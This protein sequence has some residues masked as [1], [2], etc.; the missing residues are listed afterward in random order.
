M[1]VTQPLRAGDLKY[2]HAGSFLGHTPKG[3]DYWAAYRLD[4]KGSFQWTYRAKKHIYLWGFGLI[5]ATFYLCA[6]TQEDID[7]AA[8]GKSKDRSFMFR[9]PQNDARALMPQKVVEQ[10]IL[11]VTEMVWGILVVMAVPAENH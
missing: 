4:P 2:Q 9:G 7:T 11:S 3:I 6:K 8:W 5:F 1:K 10:M